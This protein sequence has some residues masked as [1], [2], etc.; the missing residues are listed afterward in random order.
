MTRKRISAI[1]CIVLCIQVIAAPIALAADVNGKAI[2]SQGACVMDFETGEVLYEYNGNVPRVPAS[3]TKLMTIYCVYD[4]IRS[5]KITMNTAVPISQNVY[6]KAR[7]P[8][9]Q[10]VPLYYN[11][12]YTVDEMMSI[13]I[14]YSACAPA[15]A[16][17]ELVSG[18]EAA[19]V[20]LMN[21]TAKRMKINATYYDCFGVMNNKVSPIAMVTL[22]RNLIKEFPDIVVRTSKRS[23][24]FHGNTY[25]STNKLF[26]TYYYEGADG[27]KTGTTSASGY[28]FCGTAVRNGRRIIAV[29]MASASS[30]QR[31]ADMV[32]LLDYGFS[33]SAGT[34]AGIY[35]TDIHTYINGYEVPTY[36]YTD[37]QTSKPVIIAENL[38]SYGFDAAYNAD[39]HT[40]TLTYNPELSVTPMSFYRGAP[41]EE[42]FDVLKNNITKVVF[43]DGTS[44]RIIS[45]VY[46]LNGYMA[47]DIDELGTIYGFSWSDSERSAYIDTSTVKRTYGSSAIENTVFFTD[48]AST[49][50]GTEIPT[51]MYKGGEYPYAVII[52]EDL[53]N[54]GFDAAYDENTHTLSLTYNPEKAR[55]PIPMDYYKNKNGQPAFGIYNDNTSVEINIGGSKYIMKKVHSTDGY[56]FIPVDEFANFAHFSWNDAARSAS[57]EIAE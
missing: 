8:E 54:Y 23:I 33:V 13:V 28:C 41:G 25:Y 34:A 12:V 4:A 24:S 7:N 40:L 22:A 35:H 38:A 42:V 39:T 49:V 26:N 17:A 52:A 44:D 45:N 55:N 2:T 15:V 10:S 50:N 14:T 57:V 6:N 20:R 30:N 3:M 32:T 1:L 19:F 36:V 16:L 43:N 27:L 51:F 5:G 47:M 21:D 11:T 53:Q 31:F 9:Y 56:I 18:S 48:I 29:T 46:N 37:K